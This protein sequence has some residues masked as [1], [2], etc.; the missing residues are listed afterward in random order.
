MKLFRTL[1]CAFY[2]ALSFCL[3]GFGQEISPIQNYTPKT[4]GAENQNWGISQGLQKQLYFANNEGLLDF[5]GANW[6]LYS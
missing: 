4:Y 3:S 1:Q 5:N 6:Q 2:F